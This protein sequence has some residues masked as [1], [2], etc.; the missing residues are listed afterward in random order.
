MLLT[1]ASIIQ[2]C[3]DK[4]TMNDKNFKKRLDDLYNDL[5]RPKSKY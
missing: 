1:I 4:K 5:V 2:D 3:V